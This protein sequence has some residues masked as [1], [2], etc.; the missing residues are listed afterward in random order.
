[1]N[2]SKTASQT[3]S[4]PA[5][6]AESPLNMAVVRAE[7]PI[8]DQQVHGHRLVYLDSAASSQRPAVVIRTI[9]EYYAKDHANV[10]RGAYELS[11]RATRR[12]EAAR[13]KVAR[14]LGA[15]RADEVVFTRSTTESINLVSMAWGRANLRPGDV[16]VVT[17]ME[18]HSNLV[19]WQMVCEMTGAEIRAIKV[20]DDQ[21]LDLDH[22][23]A[24]LSEGNVRLVAT[25]HVSNAVGTIHPV[26]EIARRAHGVGALYLIDGAQGAPQLPIDVRA[27]DCDFYTFSGHKACGPTGIGV[28][29]GRRE[30]LESMPPY[31]GG[32]E[33]IEEVRIERSTYAP[34]PHKFEAGTPNIAGAI[35]LGAAVD[36]LQSLGLET[37][38][39]HEKRIA[40]LVLERLADEFKSITLYGPAPGV[41]RG[42][43]VSFTLADIHPHDLATILDHEGVAI[44]A[45]HHCC[46][47]LM[48]R[49]G[50]AATARASF[51]LYNAEDDLEV[52]VSGLH[53]A[54]E[55]FGI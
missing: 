29:W 32:G 27:I 35:G 40:R 20:T 23:D 12:Y 46:Q 21:C 47:P 19:P 54:Q 34:V 48:R 3:D 15:G 52:L 4:L 41:A 26:E 14:F 9:A 2:P 42:G 31:Q 50:V 43:V 8:L 55:L 7:F 44:R 25:G 24:L 28:L 1:V 33:M 36:F 11:V 18:H 16:V 51:Y 30:L 38:H 17:E 53:R 5:E 45:G 37:I 22:L 39:A 49:L 6:L 13:G 10:H